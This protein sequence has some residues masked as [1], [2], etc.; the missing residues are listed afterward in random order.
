MC[1]G[2]KRYIKPIYEDHSVIVQVS[3][4]FVVTKKTYVTVPNHYTAY[5]CDR[6]KRIACLESGRDNRL[7][8]MGQ[9]NIGKQLQVEYILSDTDQQIPWEFHGVAV[10]DA[11]TGEVFHISANGQ[12]RVE[13]DPLKLTRVFAVN[14]SITVDKMR[15]KYV[16]AVRQV[17]MPILTGFFA[18]HPVSVYDVNSLVP[19]VRDEILSALRGNEEAE[20]IGFYVTDLTVGKIRVDLNDLN[21][22]QAARKDK[23]NACV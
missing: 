7:S 12:C 16:S 4:P 8:K 13:A 2:R 3:D 1:F 9:D 20:M 6:G 17:G 15:E 19:E 5:L 21:R 14:E 18:S 11:E 22:I 23:I 10:R